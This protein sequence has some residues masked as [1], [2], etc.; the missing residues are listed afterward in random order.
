MYD[1]F[2]SIGVLNDFLK[3]KHLT[4][5]KKIHNSA[6]SGEKC[7]VCNAYWIVMI[8]GLKMS[9]GALIPHICGNKEGFASECQ[10]FLNF[11]VCIARKSVSLEE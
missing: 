6:I 7:N 2:K 5:E 9:L 8:P 4:K 3:R 11:H 10:F 1:N